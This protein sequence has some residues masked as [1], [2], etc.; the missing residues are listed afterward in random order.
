MTILVDKANS[1]LLSLQKK[2]KKIVENAE[3][4]ANLLESQVITYAMDTISGLDKC[5]QRWLY[6]F[7]STV[8]WMVEICQK[9]E[10]ILEGKQKRIQCEL[11]WQQ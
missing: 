2:K 11:V 7:G 9:Q 1:Q 8:L 5:I 4:S 3:G 6:V 10:P